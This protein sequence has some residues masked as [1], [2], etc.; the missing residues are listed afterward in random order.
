LP[1]K[2]IPALSQVTVSSD[3]SISEGNRPEPSGLAFR[4]GPAI[5]LHESLPFI[6][7]SQMPRR[8]VKIAPSKVMRDEQDRNAVPHLIDIAGLSN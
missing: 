5:L 3:S 7:V 2:A 6:G 8:P 1:F 4:Y